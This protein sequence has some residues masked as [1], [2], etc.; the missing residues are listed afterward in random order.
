V[1]L[2]LDLAGVPVGDDGEGLLREVDG[3]LASG[4]GAEVHDLDGDALAGARVRHAVVG[5]A[6]ALDHEPV[7]ADLAAVP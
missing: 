2:D 1:I 7:A 5:G 3:A 4:R 6:L